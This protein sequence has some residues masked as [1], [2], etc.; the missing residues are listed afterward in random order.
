MLVGDERLDHL[1]AE[2]LRIIQSP[3]VFSFSLDAVLLARFSYIPYQKGRVIDLCSGNGI[4]PLLISPRT[5][6]P[7]IGVEIQERLADMARRSVSYNELTD[8]IEIMQQDLR[9]IVPILGK[10]KNS[11]VTCN[12]PYFALEST[13]IKNENEHLR[14]AR[15]EVHC[16]LR[17]TIQVSADL[18]KQGGKASFVHR[19]ERLLEIIDLMRE[20]GLEPKRI[21]FVH[22]RVER[23]ANTILIEGIKGAKPGVKYLPPIIVHDAV[24]EYTAQ[25]RELL[26][27]KE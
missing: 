5:K 26:Y 16:T 21:Q 12:P 1:L 3:T 11:F 8:Q 23:E 6:V 19:P 15:H 10:G 25:V 27:G 20:Y 9:D 2:N 14:I 22:P 24:G 13:S 7:I 4:I 17:D 18:L